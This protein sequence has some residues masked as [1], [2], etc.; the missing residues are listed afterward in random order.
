MIKATD[1]KS[2]REMTGA[3]MMDAKNALTEAGGDF[4]VAK[5]LLRKKGLKTADKKAGREAKEGLVIIKEYNNQVVVAQVACETDFVAKNERF[6]EFVNEYADQIE[7]RANFSDEDVAEV[8][9]EIG[10]NIQLGT[11]IAIPLPE[12][13]NI[14]PR[15]E[16]QYVSTYIHGK[17]ADGLGRI[18]V[19]VTY[20]GD[21]NTD[22]EVGKKI[23][24]HIASAN[25]KALTVDTLDPEW[26]AKEKAFL[27]SEAL[28]SGKPAE[29]VEKMIGGRM[30]KVLKEVCL[31]NQAFVM[32]PDQTVGELAEEENIEIVSFVRLAIGE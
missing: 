23:A 4:E 24:M 21:G 15:S 25:P 14:D 7:R 13:E 29:I 32:N 9:A 28:E 17:V 20:K 12:L 8:I 11:G 3:G 19:A 22:L 2:L 5:D 6:Q 30:N 31:E 1:V 10:E 16:V 18:G 27:T 26:V